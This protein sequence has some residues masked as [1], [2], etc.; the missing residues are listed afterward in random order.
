MRIDAYPNYK[1]KTGF[2]KTPIDWTGL[3][4][5]A[6]GSVYTIPGCNTK[7]QALRLAQE[8]VNFWIETATTHQ[9]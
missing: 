8:K 4:I 3:A 7:R 6:D 2:R 9:S 5:K 1:G